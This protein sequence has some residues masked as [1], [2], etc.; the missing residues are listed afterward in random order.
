MTRPRW[1]AIVLLLGFLISDPQGATQST[2][3]AGVVT[4]GKL[5]EY[6]GNAPLLSLTYAGADI[7][8]GVAVVGHFAREAFPS[9][10][11]PLV[12]PDT[13]IPASQERF[14]IARGSGHVL[15]HPVV[16][17]GSAIARRPLTT[18]SANEGVALEGTRLTFYA[19][20]VGQ[21]QADCAAN[22]SCKAFTVIRAGTYNVIEPA[23]CNLM[24]KAGGHYSGVKQ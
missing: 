10:V 16:G 14:P 13:A 5:V 21:C 3:T 9:L 4:G 22:A 12:P 20:A 19:A 24:L 8:T 18:F 23:M 1:G 15:D 17:Q 11:G 6:Y 7:D 2:W